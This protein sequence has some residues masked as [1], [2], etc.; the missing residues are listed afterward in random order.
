MKR[1]FI[2]LLFILFICLN[3]KESCSFRNET[4]GYNGFKWGMDFQDFLK[5]KSTY[6]NS[7]IRGVTV[8]IGYEFFKDKLYGVL[9]NFPE[10]KRGKIVDYFIMIHGRPTLERGDNLY[11]VGSDTKITIKRKDVSIVSK[12]IEKKYIKSKLRK[13]SLLE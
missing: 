10:K 4:A 5:S 7:R 3:P 13:K 1:F 6:K 2:V 8:D 9:I 11:W 12:K